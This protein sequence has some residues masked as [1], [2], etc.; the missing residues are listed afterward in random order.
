[1]KHEIK[2]TFMLTVVMLLG[3]CPAQA[4]TIWTSG[5]HVI[6]DDN[7]PFG[8]IWMYNDA[9]LDIFGGEINRLA[10]YD[11][12]VTDWFGGQMLILWAHDSSIINIRGGTLGDLWAAE[13]S[14]INLYAYDVIYDPTGGYYGLGSIEGRYLD[15]NLYFDFDLDGSDTYSHINIVPEPTTLLLFGLGGL[16]LRRRYYKY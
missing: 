15:N 10:A 6:T 8:E 3:V 5:H 11:V 9:T 7:D 16:L 14:L 13:N 1:M 2:I 4:D 12:T